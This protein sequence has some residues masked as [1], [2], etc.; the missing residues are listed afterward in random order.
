MSPNSIPVRRRLIFLFSLSTNIF[1][2]RSFVVEYLSGLGSF[3]NVPD[4]FQHPRFQLSHEVTK[5]RLLRSNPANPELCFDLIKPYLRI[6]WD[7][8]APYHVSPIRKTADRCSYLRVAS[9]LN[10]TPGLST[11]ANENY[12]RGRCKELKD[13]EKQWLDCWKNLKR[14]K[15]EG[16]LSEETFFALRHTV[17]TIPELIKVNARRKAFPPF[18][19]SSK[20]CLGLVLQDGLGR[21]SS[22]TAKMSLF[23]QRKTI[24]SDL[25]MCSLEPHSS[26]VECNALYV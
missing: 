25:P 14:N 20:L 11:L 13:H 18:V 10:V 6:N 17:N 1:K 16:C 7:Y 22:Y 24:D 19:T 23:W 8:L 5:H 9:G 21:V 26:G 4:I 3:Y 15:R 2:R 12:L